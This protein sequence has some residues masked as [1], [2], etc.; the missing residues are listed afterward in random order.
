MIS[1]SWSRSLLSKTQLAC[2]NVPKGKSMTTNSTTTGKLQK[3]V[4][5]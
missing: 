4:N 2:K 5:T 3:G 1:Q